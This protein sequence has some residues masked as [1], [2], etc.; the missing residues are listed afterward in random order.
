MPKYGNSVTD[1]QS[2]KHINFL[3]VFKITAAA[4]QRSQSFFVS[5]PFSFRDNFTPYIHLVFV[6]RNRKTF[7][8]ISV[9]NRRMGSQSAERWHG[10]ITYEVKKSQN[11]I[12]CKKLANVLHGNKNPADFT[13]S[14]GLQ[15]DPKRRTSAMGSKEYIAQFLKTKM[16]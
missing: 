1:L 5:R 15:R 3:Y 14:V 16:Q 4:G 6:E 11:S 10:Q 12:T 8:G 13:Y 2:F 7:V 9:R